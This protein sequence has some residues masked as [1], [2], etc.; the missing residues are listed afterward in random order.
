M[1]NCKHRYILKC[2]KCDGINTIV[3]VRHIKETFDLCVNDTGDDIKFS[4][5]ESQVRDVNNE[6]MDSDMYSE[7]ENLSCNNC[8]GYYNLTDKSIKQ[9]IKV[10][11]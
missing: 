10:I 2:K 8:N 9:L 5:Y 6:F 7:K 11:E 1:T 3:F 4:N